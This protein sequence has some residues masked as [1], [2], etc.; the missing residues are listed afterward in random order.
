MTSDNSTGATMNGILIYGNKIHDFANWDTTLDAYHHDG[1]HLFQVNNNS[2][3][4]GLSI[5][6]NYIYGAWGANMN[7]AIY[8]E[9]D[10]SVT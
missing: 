6:N 3:V 8:I 4:T 10:N 2:A 9:E 5:Y 1:M 7:A